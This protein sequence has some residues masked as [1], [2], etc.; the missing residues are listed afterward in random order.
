MNDL[1]NAHTAAHE[2]NARLTMKAWRDAE[3]REANAAARSAWND[4]PRF[5]FHAVISMSGYGKVHKVWTQSAEFL[6]QPY[7]GSSRWNSGRARV[8]TA[9]VTCRKCLR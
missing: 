3:G 8:T 9:P 2:E 7:C 5:T 4:L 6:D 1:T